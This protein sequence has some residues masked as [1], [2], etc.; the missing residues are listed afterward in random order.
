M[1][2]IIIKGAS[3]H[4]LRNIDVR[5]ARNAITVVSGVSGAGKSTLVLNIILREAQR[6]FFNTM[7]LHKRKLLQGFTRPAVKAI[8]GLSPAL[9]LPQ[10]LSTPPAAA[11]VGGATGISELWRILFAAL[12]VKKCPQHNIPT[13][14]YTTTS[15][16][17]ALL[18]TPVNTNLVLAAPLPATQRNT[19]KDWH[20]LQRQH[21]RVIIDGKL[22]ALDNHE[23]LPP[24]TSAN[25]VSAVIDV[26]HIRK[27][28]ELR[29]VRSIEQALLVGNGR[30]SAAH[31]V[32]R[33]LQNTQH[34]STA[35][36][37][38]QCNF[39]WP[40][41]EAR[42]FANN[43]NDCHGKGHIAAQPCAACHGT[44]LPAN[45]HAITVAAYSLPQLRD[46]TLDAL[47]GVVRELL[48]TPQL[49]KHLRTVLQRLRGELLQ[50]QELGLDYLTLATRLHSLSSGELQ[51][52]RIATF[53]NE[54]LNGVIYIFDEPS[55]GLAATEVEQL[56]QKFVRL[57]KNGNTIIIVDHSRVI[58]EKA[59]RIIDLG[60]GGG[61]QGG[62]VLAS[63]SFGECERFR[64]VS[65]TAEFLCQPLPT[66]LA[67]GGFLPLSR[68]TAQKKI[69]AAPHK[70]LEIL[71]PRGH[72]LHIDRVRLLPRSINIVTG[73]A[74]A[75]KSSLIE[76][77]LYRSLQRRERGAAINC[78]QLR[79]FEAMRKIYFVD[80][81]PLQQRQRSMVATQ[82]DIFGW[83]R[84]L[85][86][87]LKESQIA[88]FNATDFALS[89]ASRGRCAHCRGMGMVAASVAYLPPTPC[90][91]CNGRRYDAVL[92]NITWRGFNLSAVL[93]LSLDSAA[94]FFRN[95]SK[96][97]AVLQ[98]A[99]DLGLGHLQLGRTTAQLSGGESQR[100][101]LVPCLAKAD[102]DTL[103]LLDE[104]GRGLH[105][106]D[107]AKL[108]R[109]LQKLREAGAT[110]VLIEHN[111]ELIAACD[112]LI[113]L[114]PGGGRYGGRLL[115]EGVP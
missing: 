87:Q 27:G 86:G 19:G 103:L 64:A 96:V 62:E 51:K 3:E 60:R 30:C 12:G 40:P 72:N 98:A 105:S 28:C 4:N 92:D 89:S 68:S 73:V 61:E 111:A 11:S 16:R 76:R 38:P 100:L 32:Q 29:L 56:W 34:F 47:Q 25:T 46:M 59:D 79:G 65:P 75:G 91:V 22:Y 108:L 52:I 102:R 85:F 31:Y 39:T 95:F 70:F 90:H 41:L 93:E 78:Q 43:C 63:F 23:T 97:H 57:K 10:A 54:S 71:Q 26:I 112:W 109:V 17:D 37:C 83:L 8:S 104:P 50:L 77:C 58:L 113:H 99:V 44:G 82:L 15:I 67:R 115:S 35:A 21:M 14:A 74:G 18:A 45:L 69:T 42:H 9:I 110:L 48:A 20:T 6:R 81:R 94:Q 24:V 106:E 1:S 84:R 33:Q 5:I 107:I 80:R 101:Q 66:H 2:D 36:S 7:S 49:A 55:Q 53:I 88:G 13:M 114:G